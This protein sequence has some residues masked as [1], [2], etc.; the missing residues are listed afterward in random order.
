MLNQLEENALNQKTIECTEWEGCF[1]SDVCE[2]N[3]TNC[4]LRLKIQH[5]PLSPACQKAVDDVDKMYNAAN[6]ADKE[7]YNTGEAINHGTTGS[8][9][10][11]CAKRE[12]INFIEGLAE[13]DEEFIIID[14][15]LEYKNCATSSTKIEK[16]AFIAKAGE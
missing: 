10:S 15:E 8:G 13:N 6:E 1:F 2:R 16:G 14:P 5:K 4:A 3:T 7:F 12:M 9:M 11:L